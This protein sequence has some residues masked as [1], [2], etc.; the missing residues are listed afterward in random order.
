MEFIENSKQLLFE[1]RQELRKITWSTREHVTAST[2]VV[3]GVVIIIS[4]FLGIADLVLAK[5][6]K[7]ILS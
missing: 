2:W 3:M 1:A 6:I 4:I 7:Y 5:V